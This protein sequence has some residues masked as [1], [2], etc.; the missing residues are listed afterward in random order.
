M[1][2]CDPA[3][4]D[5]LADAELKEDAAS[6]VAL[7]APVAG[8]DSAHDVGCEDSPRSRADPA[9]GRRDTRIW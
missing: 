4:R 5:A 7:L 9:D 1:A 8:Q 2:S 6:A 3:T